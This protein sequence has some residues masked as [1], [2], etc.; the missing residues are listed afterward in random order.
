MNTTIGSSQPN[1][2][3]LWN[4]LE[5]ILKD[6]LL[7]FDGIVQLFMENLLSPSCQVNGHRTSHFIKQGSQLVVNQL[8]RNMAMIFSINS[9]IFQQPL[10][11]RQKLRHDLVFSNNKKHSLTGLLNKNKCC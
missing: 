2:A 9:L 3:F 5:T 7:R 11:T 8:G 6:I 1:T 10:F 4:S